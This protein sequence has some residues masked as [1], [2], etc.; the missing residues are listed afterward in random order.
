MSRFLKIKVRDLTNLCIKKD[1]YNVKY[2]NVNAKNIIK[3]KTNIIHN[4]LNCIKTKIIHNDFLYCNIYVK[5]IN[6][7]VHLLYMYSIMQNS[8]T[9]RNVLQLL[10]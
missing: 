10:K 6:N 7:K 5:T 8:D 1:I 2:F 4:D 3:I 9:Y